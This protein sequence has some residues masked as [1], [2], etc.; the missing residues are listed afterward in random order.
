MRIL[1]TEAS[2]GWGGQEIRILSE[3]RGMIARGHQVELACPSTARIYT[4]AARFGVPVHALAIGRK[5]FSWLAAMR[6][7]LKTHAFDVINTH[8]STDAWLAAVA[9]RTLRQSPP[10]VRTRHISAAIPKNAS[11]RWLYARSTRHIVT[12]GEALR[13]QLLKDLPLQ[14]ENLTSVPTGVDTAH[15][16]PLSAEDKAALR[17]RLGLPQGVPLVGIIA[18]LRSWKGHRYLLEA[19]ARYAPAEAHLLIVGDGPQHE[20]LTA[21]IASLGLHGRVTMPGNQPDV[22]AWMQSLDI[23]VLPSYANEGVPQALMQAMSTALPCITTPVGAILELAAP[24]ETA[25]VVPPED[26]AALGAALQRLLADQASGG[27][28]SARLG[29]AARERI[30]GD[31]AVDRMLDRMETIFHK[32]TAGHHAGP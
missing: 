17:I 32:V 25:L 10:I 22:Q 4:E 20:A 1:H 7:F 15:F 28:W 12:T 5:G 8:S 31:Y 13:L 27:A 3:A 26:V 11:S 9:C 6:A 2:G 21:Q 14:P 29:A 23:F 16:T 30:V 18:T 19:F 24:D